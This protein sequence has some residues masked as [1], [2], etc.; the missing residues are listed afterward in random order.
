[1]TG[2]QTCALPISHP[3]DNKDLVLPGVLRYTIPTA[4]WTA[5][6]ALII[7][8]VV[9][10]FADTGVFAD[11]DPAA[12]DAKWDGKEM[13]D[14]LNQRIASAVMIMFLGITGAMQLLVVQPYTKM[15]SADVP[16]REDRDIR[17]VI[18][19]FL[20]VGV[21]IL[22]YNI[23]FLLD[24]MYIPQLPLMTQFA[25]ILLAVV[26]LI[27]HHYIVTTK[28]LDF[29]NNYV[30]RHYRNAFEK[31]RKKENELALSGKEEKW[32]M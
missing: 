13:V 15:L 32:R 1:M 12:W 29:I 14:S 5:I 30:V 23:E 9:F 4:I 10:N 16:P 6:W 22:F 31:K 27:S 3:S 11:Y 8:T 19:T 24:L 2:V 26:W 20:L 7:Y 18:L 28:R 17:P 21:A 25:V